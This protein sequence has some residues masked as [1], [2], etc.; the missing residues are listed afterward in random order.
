MRRS[1]LQELKHLTDVTWF[2]PI[3]EYAQQ[4]KTVEIIPAWL[5]NGNILL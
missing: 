2:K 4:L 1:N 5:N 3:V